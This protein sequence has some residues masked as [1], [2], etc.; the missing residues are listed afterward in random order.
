MASARSSVPFLLIL[1][2]AFPMHFWVYSFLTGEATP[3]RIVNQAF[4]L[5]LAA[6]CTMLAMLGRNISATWS[7][8]SAAVIRALLL[9]A[10][11][12]LMLGGTEFTTYD[13]TLR[14]FAPGWR[15]EQLARH[16]GLHAIEGSHQTAYVRPFTNNDSTPPTFM[17]ADVT[18]DPKN[19]INRCVAD[20]YQLKDVI[21]MRRT[22]Y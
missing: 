8:R 13:H 19:W 16:D 21:Q 11:G 2:A 4:V 18:P 3:G 1:F 20:Y 22:S 7:V 14:T 17:G 6:A 9:A 15:A 5:A 10:A 12:I